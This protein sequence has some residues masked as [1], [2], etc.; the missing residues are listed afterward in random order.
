M[1]VTRVPQIYH[2]SGS[3]FLAALSFIKGASCLWIIGVAL[4]F[5]SVET[6]H[7]A[8]SKQRMNEASEGMISSRCFCS[9]LPHSFSGL[10]LLLLHVSPGTLTISSLLPALISGAYSSIPLFGTASS[11]SE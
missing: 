4:M 3:L 7:T 9:V 11:L 1:R 5:G 8:S 2:L 10:H 6:S